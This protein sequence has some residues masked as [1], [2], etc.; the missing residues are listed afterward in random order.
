MLKVHLGVTKTSFAHLMTLEEV[1]SRQRGQLIHKQ[2]YGKHSRRYSACLEPSPGV[3]RQSKMIT[4][5]ARVQS[6]K[7]L[8]SARLRIL[9]FILRAIESRGNEEFNGKII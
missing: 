5:D 9:N 8:T 7:G 1:S 4:K 6:R 3:D 2:G